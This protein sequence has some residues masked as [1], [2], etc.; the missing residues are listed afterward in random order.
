MSWHLDAACL[1]LDSELF[2]PED[3]S[4]GH[5]ADL[6]AKN[7]LIN[8]AKTVCAGCLVIDSCRAA[9]MAEPFGIYGGLTATERRKIRRMRRNHDQDE[10]VAA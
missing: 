9:H 6:K 7:A 1:G 8:E 4:G 5:R 2:H 10:V 3:F